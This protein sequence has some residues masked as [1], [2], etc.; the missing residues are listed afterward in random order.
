MS[1]LA[2]LQQND[3][4]VIADEL[5]GCRGDPEAFVDRMFDWNAGELKGK[6]PEV[7]QREVLRAIRDGLPDKAIRIAVASGHGV[8]KTALVSWLC[9]WAMST[10]TD[11]PP[12]VESYSAFSYAKV[13]TTPTHPVSGPD[14]TITS[15]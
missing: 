15:A 7:W 4:E 9:L 6:S 2:A 13:S 5:V 3:L 11:G 12:R 10:C 1:E 14:V 8:G